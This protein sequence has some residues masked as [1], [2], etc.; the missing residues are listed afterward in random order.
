M[1][2]FRQNHSKQGK[3]ASDGIVRVGLFA[4]IVGGLFFLFN[5]FTGGGEA[6]TD[7][8]PNTDYVEVQPQTERLN[9]LPTTKEGTIIRHQ[10]Y[11]LSYA[12]TFE[13]AEWVAYELTKERLQEPWV[14]RKNAYFTEDPNVSSG[15]ASNADYKT[16]SYER[17]HLVPAA[18]RAFSKEA[19]QET[20]YFSNISPQAH[21][22]NNGVW[23]EL[24]ELT[25]SWAKKFKK[26][27]VITGPMLNEPPK[28]YIGVNE[29]AVPVG[30]FKVLLDVTE[31]EHK[32]IAFIIPN[33][34]SY[35]PLFEFAVSIDEVEA[36]TGLDFFNDLLED[37]YEEELEG[38]FNTDLWPFSKRKYE[39]RVNKWNK[40]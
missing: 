19:M 40:E 24:E 3:G 10:Y 7:S 36:K 28:S 27:Y 12:E 26:L 15:S 6:T 9:Y 29:V 2:K 14:D 1:A 32:G 17:G 22:F 18:D 23:R 33:T 4:A 16:S 34:I 30:Y 31:P 5:R 38:S 8:N 20:F 25:R 11:T 37:D 13:Q 21:N 35:D 39:I